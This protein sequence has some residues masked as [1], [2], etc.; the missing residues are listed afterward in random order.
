MTRICIAQISYCYVTQLQTLTLWAF[1]T[2][3]AKLV[4]SRMTL[5]NPMD[6]SLPGSSVHGIF[7]ARILEWVALPSPPRDLSDPGIKPMCP[8]APELQADSLLLSHGVAHLYWKVKVKSLSRVRLFATCGLSPPSS[9]VH[10]IL[11][12][13]ILEWVAISFSICTRDDCKYF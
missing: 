8:E 4:Q 9:S 10:G 11:Q 3:A 1:S 5:C 13:R 6:Y 7:Q 12:A 2:A